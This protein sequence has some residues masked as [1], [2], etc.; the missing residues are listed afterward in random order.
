MSKKNK[1][2]EKLAKTFCTTYH[3][4]PRKTML[5]SYY[6]TLVKRNLLTFTG[7]DQHGFDDLRNLSF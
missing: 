1:M 4:Y 6:S 7:D 5:L 2:E 3:N